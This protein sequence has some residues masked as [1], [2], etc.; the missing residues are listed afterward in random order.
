MLYTLW[1]YPTGSVP[2]RS[3]SLWIHQYQQHS[4]LM[5][6]MDWNSGT[7]TDQN[8]G[9]KVSIL[10]LQR[11]FCTYVSPIW[12]SSHFLPFN[13]SSLVSMYIYNFQMGLCAF[14]SAKTPYLCKCPF[15][16]PDILKT[17]VYYCSAVCRVSD[18]A[19]HEINR[20][21]IKIAW[22]VLMWNTSHR[23]QQLSQVASSTSSQIIY[24]SW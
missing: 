12:H 22:V 19:K 23:S 24:Q 4:Q 16:K 9:T 7:R 11:L 20:C 18:K 1:H 2:Y 14:C 6:E 13:F 8:F 5:L 21:G 17:Q 15:C 10:L 3:G